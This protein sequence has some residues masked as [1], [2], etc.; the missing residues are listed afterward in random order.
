MSV[1]VDASVA[2][3]WFSEET[4]SEEAEAVLSAADP[5]IAPDLVLAEIASALAKKV[6]AKILRKAQVMSAI[7]DAPRY[8]DRLIPMA[9]LA[10][11][12]TELAIEFRH[13]VYDCIYV[14]LAER[15][16]TMLVTADRRLIAVAKKAKVKVKAL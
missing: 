13:P 14:A 5:I 10:A 1:V 2:V 15:E 3:K 9:E 6:G 11:R 8:F 4:G 12:A 7:A 16:N